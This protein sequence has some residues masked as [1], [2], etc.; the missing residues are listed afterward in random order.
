MSAILEYMK[1]QVHENRNI[2]HDR[3]SNKSSYPIDH[4][5]WATMQG[6][7]GSTSIVVQD[8][9]H[10]VEDEDLSVI[11]RVYDTP[12]NVEYR[13]AGP[14]DSHGTAIISYG[15]SHIAFLTAQYLNGK[16]RHSINHGSAF[17]V[18]QSQLFS[19]D[20]LA[21][22]QRQLAPQPRYA[23]RPRRYPGA[24][25]EIPPDPM[26][27]VQNPRT[28]S[29]IISVMNLGLDVTTADLVEGFSI[30]DRAVMVYSHVTDRDAA[31]ARLIYH[32]PG[33]AR[34]IAQRFH[35]LHWPNESSKSLSV[36]HH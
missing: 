1:V 11:F 21:M 33:A 15:A 17:S 30:D 24:Y 22:L 4:I 29:C 7:T 35:G 8:I 3:S 27:E 13:K 25:S 9:H 32:S 28:G 16:K 10:D 31:T 19:Q 23:L 2:L 18:V 36:R 34:Q 14:G 12:S 26:P 20:N 6:D 5:H